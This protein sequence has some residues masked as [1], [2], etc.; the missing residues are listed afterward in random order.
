MP[1][2]PSFLNIGRHA[3]R[4]PRN[5]EL[6]QNSGAGGGLQAALVQAEALQELRDL[7]DR[8]LCDIGIRRDEVTAILAGVTGITRLRLAL[9]AFTRW[10]GATDRVILATATLFL[11]LALQQ[12]EQFLVSLRFT[13]GSLCF[14]APFLLLSAMIATSVSVCEVRC[15]SFGWRNP[16]RRAAFWRQS[17]TVGGLL[18]KWLTPVFLIESLLVA[19]I[20]NG[21]VV[22]WLGGSYQALLLLL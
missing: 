2:A 6:G 12:P 17:L 4:S 15:E 21:S 14:A 7:D 1:D 11:A 3:A 19:T 5:S 10:L 9:A 8:R 13:F 22:R 18:L 16:E 20:A